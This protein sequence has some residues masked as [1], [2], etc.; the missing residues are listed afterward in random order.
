MFKV[1]DHVQW[2]SQ[3]GGSSKTKQGVVVALAPE[4]SE[5]MNASPCKYANQHFPNHSRMFDG[6]SWERGGVLVEVR[7]GKTDRAKPKLYMPRV[8]L[9]SIV[10]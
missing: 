1:G 4:G 9:L 8:K 10:E 7:D 2:T 6:L 5:R 3:A